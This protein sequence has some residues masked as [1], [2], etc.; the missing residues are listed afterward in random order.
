MK[1]YLTT[2]KLMLVA[3]FTCFGLGAWADE[4]T[5]AYTGGTT[6]NMVA[7]GSN[8]AATFGLD[9][10]KWSVVGDK[11]ANSNAPGLNKAN[12]FR[13]YWSA[14][15]GNTITVS[16]LDGTTIS[17]IAITFTGADYSNVSV[18]VG[19]NA[20]NGE[21]GVFPINA[22][23]F[24]LG[25]ANTSN[26][27]VRMSKLVIYTGGS[28]PGPTPDP[29]PEPEVK[30]YNGISEIPFA[31]VTS[32]GW[33]S[34]V[35]VAQDKP[36]TVTFRNG[37]NIYVTDGTGAILIYAPRSGVTLKKGDKFAG[38]LNGTLKTYNGSVELAVAKADDLAVE[39][40]S[41][42]NECEPQELDA[43]TFVANPLAYDSRL[44]VMKK[45]NLNE[46]IP[47][48]GSKRNIPATQG[49]TN[50]IVRT[51]F[52][53]PEKA[54]ADVLYDIVGIAVN[55]VKSGTATPELYP[56]SISE[57]PAS[58]SK[59]FTFTTE[60]YPGMGYGVT[61]G[62]ADIAAI[63][64]FLGVEELT[65]S[66]LSFINPDGTL[67]AW[68]DYQAPTNYDGWCNEEG[69]AAAWNSTTHMICI[70]FFEALEDG[71]Y[72]I[73]DMNE[74][75]EVGKSY[76]A[77]WRLLAGDKTAIIATTVTFVEKPVLNLTFDQ[78][79]QK[80]VISLDFSSQ[81]GN[82][83]EGFTANVDVPAILAKLGVESLDGVDIY[84]VQSD[85]SL[86]DNYKLGTTD[87]W[88]NADGDWQGWGANARI[89]VKSNFAAE[90]EQIYFIGGMD[91]QTGSPATFTATYAFVK[92]GSK[93]AVVLKV[94]LS[95]SDK[96]AI[97][98]DKAHGTYY[99][100][101][102]EPLTESG[103]G[104]KWVSTSED[105]QI[106]LKASSG[107][108]VANG[109]HFGPDGVTYT[110]TASEGYVITGYSLT[111]T[112]FPDGSSTL[113][114]EG[115]AAQPFVAGEANEVTGLSAE[116]TT[117]T[118]TD[119]RA[120]VTE[121]LVYVGKA[122]PVAKL[123]ED[124]TC[125]GTVDVTINGE[126]GAAF[127]G[128]DSEIFQEAA[129]S[130]LIG[131]EWG[132]EYG[133]GPKT[134]EGKATFTD[135]YSC[136]PNPGFWCLADGTADVW[137]N[138]TFGVSVI[139]AEDYSTLNF[140]AWT[141][142]EVTEPLTTTFYFVNEDTKEYVA[143]N[144]T[145]K[146]EQALPADP[147]EAALALIKDGEKY[148][149]FSEVNGTKY[150][151]DPDGYLVDNTDKAG[152]F[153]FKK[154]SAGNHSEFG[155]FGFQL[156][157][158]S[159]PDLSGNDAVLNSG[160]IRSYT[161]GAR[162]D[163]E[164]QVFLYKDGKYAIRATNA[165]GGDSGWALV[166]KAYWTVNE[167]TEGPVAEYSFDQNF[168][169]QIEVSDDE[170]A[171][172]L[173]E[174]QNWQKV[175]QDKVGLVTDASQYISNA[176]DPAEG[177]YEALLDGQYS[178]FFHSTWHGG[179]YDPQADHYLQANLPEAA[180]KFMIYFKKRSQNNNNR[181]T[182]IDISAS[183]D[184]E[185]FA[186]VTSIT[187]GLP[188]EAEPI[189]FL[190]EAI[191]LPEPSKFIRFT[192]PSTNNGAKTGDHVFFTFSEFYIL[193]A[194]D[195]IVQLFEEMPAVVEKYAGYT[196]YTD[197]SPADVQEIK[198]ILERIDKEDEPQ[199]QTLDLAINIERMA[200]QGY[201]AQECE[202]NLAEA[203]AFLGVEAIT[204]DMLRVVNPDGTMI[205]N[206]AP[207]DGWFNGEGVA[208][209]WGANTKINVKFFQA[210]P[211]GKFTICDMNDAD[212]VGKTYTVKWA[213]EAGNK[214]VNYTINVKFIEYTKPLYKPEIVK[215]ITIMHKE[216]AE[217]A[218]SE[219]EPAPTFDVAEVCEALGIANIS[220]AKPYIVNVTNGDFVE[221]TTDGWRDAKGDAAPWGE[222]ANG[223]CLKLND[224]ASGAF[225][226]TGAHDANFKAGSRYIA[227]WGL[228]AAEKAVL[229]K[230]YVMFVNDLN[231]N[232]L[233]TEPESPYGFYGDE[234]AEVDEEFGSDYYIYNIA[235]QQFL[236]GGNSWGTQAS[237]NEV[238]TRFTVEALEDGTY[239]LDS[240][241]SNGGTSHYLG[242]N[243]YVDAQPFGFTLTKV[244]DD[245]EDVNV[246]TIS[247][248]TNLLAA[249][250]DNTIVTLDGADAA[251]QKAQW[252][253]VSTSERLKKL[254]KATP[255][256]PVD[257]TFMIACSEFSR[258]D[259]YKNS[260][261][262]A[263]SIGGINENMCAEKWNTNFDINQVVQYIPAG[264]YEVSV[265][266][267]Y[268]AGS[269]ADNTDEQNAFLYA[270][271]V[272]TPLMKITAGGQA[273]K[274]GAYNTESRGVFVPNNMNEASTA[275]TAG[276]YSDNKLITTVFDL[277]MTL[278]V[279]KDVL[280]GADWT[281]FDSFRIK[282]LGYDATTTLAAAAEALA[283]KVA[284]AE[285]VEETLDAE[286]AALIDAAVKANNKAYNTSWEYAIAVNAIQE[287]IDKAKAAAGKEDMPIATG[288]DGIFADGNND[289]FDLSGRKVSKVQK[290]IYIVNGKKVAIK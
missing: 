193:P 19:G 106:T 255:Q 213:L 275:F 87:G 177:S 254:A 204:T 217:T 32:T 236:T 133:I 210:I 125:K 25:N 48:A 277:T 167:G 70:K 97:I 274:G 105:P 50:F 40:I 56:I 90:S 269:P 135:A 260:W 218:Y 86:D 52:L 100:G 198:A 242:S 284:E 290:G 271:G 145:L 127:N 237:R 161:G 27:Q 172:L 29:D 128:I 261:N 15:G 281:I 207:Y 149:V 191:T 47:D 118:I 73:C 51:E 109:M 43:A 46:E 141:K 159:N 9:A 156:Q 278:G 35:V 30:T 272:E 187:E 175:I 96:I 256:N 140:R 279:K 283:K 23:S 74:A 180:E 123:V 201:T 148:R 178:T 131:E 58:E 142:A 21:N 233:I 221:N 5:M 252:L 158:F 64:E 232:E 134:D 157:A 184:G 77:K 195:N 22:S 126:S 219:A 169:W 144:V 197:L 224:P 176:K 85:N 182:Q 81:C 62:K 3:L 37:Q 124:Y 168:I 55:Y 285:A 188:T 270:N 244:A 228:V 211:D 103:W 163:W 65:T 94:N 229:L 194:N 89:C 189:D 39:V 170:R 16:S 214:I 154:V 226:Y 114:P 241:V 111:A 235:T 53:L 190:S 146:A 14:D 220:E 151:V 288:I 33:A 13:L 265:Q 223:F 78:L 240:H 75:D 171:E 150:Y 11:G 243:G 164:A 119:G 173:A 225:D 273:E 69:A 7:D 246:Y 257:A 238:G 280:I 10:A 216:L 259:Q 160:H 18:T 138:S 251:D 147:Y 24:V 113:T 108:N 174:V 26:V 276:A 139:W 28:T 155:E 186:P 227:Q 59:E 215:T 79:T 181:P 112:N 166:A 162:T 61:E 57:S 205:A 122:A 192:V 116:T 98:V 249:N 179:E 63:K 99:N 31:E 4:V 130:A 183:N 76:T 287:A 115:G 20:V 91:G 110:L 88:R 66:M 80:D 101:S 230:V 54:A 67:I 92:K 121:F 200:T 1:H 165:P 34:K 222:S 231:D 95:Y 258:N 267:F 136:D 12:D 132:A 247:D 286:G 17:S 208:T 153:T 68:A 239:T 93:D 202:V 44:V 282:Y 72:S 2:L 203:K 289:I 263:P 60:R 41:E 245:N 262:G 199:V 196:N 253:L 129:I 185:N 209:S 102:N 8:E 264:Q 38:T 234:L 266:G 206:Y 137:A 143:Y 6:T 83:Y 212:E 107:I 84:A 120:Q 71:I 250:A 49:T 82:A 268:R 152:T 36:W 45:V 104:A 42:D 248:G 117:F